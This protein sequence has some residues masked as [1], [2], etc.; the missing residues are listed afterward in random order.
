MILP[1]QLT[2]DLF[3]ADLSP[4]GEKITKEYDSYIV[5]EKTGGLVVEVTALGVWNLESEKF[6]FRSFISKLELDNFIV[7]LRKTLNGL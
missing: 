4:K 1:T 5:K 6:C 2:T 7:T 3:V